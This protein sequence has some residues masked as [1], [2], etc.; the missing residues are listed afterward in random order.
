LVFASY[1]KEIGN[2]SD[3]G[4]LRINL[5][6]QDYTSTE[7]LGSLGAKRAEEDSPIVKKYEQFDVITE[8]ASSETY[9]NKRDGDKQLIASL[10]NKKIT[11]LAA[12]PMSDAVKY[13]LL[14]Y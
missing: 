7:K 5:G 9:R 1:D 3:K 13:R 8:F 10:P 14:I 2:T 6:I 11:K 12:D 4:N